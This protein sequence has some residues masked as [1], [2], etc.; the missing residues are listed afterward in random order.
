M[1]EIFCK[2][3]PFTE[4]CIIIPQII[5]THRYVPFIFSKVQGN[6]ATKTLGLFFVIIACCT[7]K[8]GLGICSQCKSVIGAFPGYDVDNTGFPIGI[9]FSRRR[10]DQFYIFQNVC[11][12]LA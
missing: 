3:I 2:Y 5:P 10:S 6:I 7:W 8:S 11:R 9:I 12:Q 1:G 4:P